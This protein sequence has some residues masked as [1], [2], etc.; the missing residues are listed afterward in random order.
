MVAFVFSFIDRTILGL[1]IV[2]VKADLGL[3]DTHMGLLTGL[4]FAIF[5]TLMGLP[6]GRLSDRRSRRLIVGV[7]IFFWSIMTAAC[8]L[9]RSF[10][11]LFLARI[12]V[13]VGE[14]A[15]SPAAY[16]LIAD[17]FPPHKLGRAV[18]VYQSGAFFGG[19][20]AFLVGGAVLQVLNTMGPQTFPVVG[21]LQPWQMAFFIVATP[22]IFVAFL[23]RTIQEPPRRGRMAGHDDGVPLREAWAYAF[24][25]RRVFGAH[26]AGFAMLAIPISNVLVWAPT[27]LVRT[28]G[29]TVPEA[30]LT[31]GTILLIFSPAGVYTGGWLSDYLRRKGYID[32][33]MRV[34][35]ISAL[36]LIPLSFVTASFGGES[37]TL[38]G[39]CVLVFVAALSPG[40]A[41]AALPLVT[42]N[43]LR[44]QVAAVYML[45]L[46]LL[47]GFFGPTIIGVITDYVFGDESAVG[48]SIL[49]ANVVASPIAALLIW[50]GLR[51][52][53]EEAAALQAAGTTE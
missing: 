2:P 17:F 46:N 40:V 1:M 31:F 47:T 11:Q 24:K 26:F 8:G 6:L 32:A 7:G 33:P 44:A 30:G 4:A 28:F 39:L 52:Y 45:F 16:S 36:S 37:V 9:A 3:T 50:S 22:G 18:A 15:L 48:Y 5:Y 34:G 25:R 10:W 23:L 12:G 49:L 20:I 51:A 29:Y 42:P 13:G 41:P 43:Q 27:W 38:A 19:G 35:L 14:A 21:V 53:R